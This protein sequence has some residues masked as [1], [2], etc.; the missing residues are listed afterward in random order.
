VGQSFSTHFRRAARLAV[1]VAAVSLLATACQT[2]DNE[3]G[4]GASSG[5]GDKKIA[6]L[7]PETKTARY[8]AADRPMFE[9]KVKALC[10]DCEIIYSNADQKADQQQN[11]ADAALTNGAKVMVLDPVDSASAASIVAKAKS[12]NVPVISYD[13]LITNAD[14]D[15]YISFDNKKVGQLQG[16]AL[17]D[18]LKE[19]GKSSGT[20][21][22]INGAPTDNNAKL[23]K[24]G[25]HS[26]LDDSGFKIGKEYDTP[27]W[28]PDKAQD[29]MEQAITALG[30]DGFDGVYAANDGTGGGAIAAMKSQGIKPDDRPTTGQDAELAAIQRILAGEQYM[31]IYKPIRPEAE[32]AAELAVNLVNGDKAA[33]DALAKKTENNGQK[34]VPSIIFDPVVVT[35]DNVKDT[36]VKDNFHPVDQLCSGAAASACQAAGIS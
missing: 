13:R 8:E 29:E 19:D 10:A 14:V 15:Y 4:G 34:D 12:Q 35:K 33:A 25:A 30:K 7:L 3:G 32:A 31:T 21:V 23:F 17:V 6:L 16:Q 26:V 1:M 2:T 24:Q 9:A 27:D 5:G 22:M 28:S 36:I 18:K 11:Q 20:V